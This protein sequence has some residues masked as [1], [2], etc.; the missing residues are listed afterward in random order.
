[1]PEYDCFSAQDIRL[2][3]DPNQLVRSEHRMEP[4]WESLTLTVTPPIH[5]QK[6]AINNFNN[7]LHY[8]QSKPC[9]VLK[10]FI[11]SYLIAWSVAENDPENTVKETQGDSIFIKNH[12]SNVNQNCYKFHFVYA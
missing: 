10:S 1:M 7:N 2:Y 11:Q 6:F 9:Q 3:W 12:L 8:C 4:W 5:L